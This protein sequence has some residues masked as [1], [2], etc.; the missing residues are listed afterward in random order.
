MKD[1][2]LPVGAAQLADRLPAGDVRPLTGLPGAWRLRVGEWRVR[3]RL[4]VARRI[5]DVTAVKPRG[6]AYQP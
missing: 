2:P 4:D 3:Y 5:I 6:S 1:I